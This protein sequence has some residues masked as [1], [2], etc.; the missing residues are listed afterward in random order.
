MVL[1]GRA[2][3]ELLQCAQIGVHVDQLDRTVKFE[4]VGAV[5]PDVSPCAEVA[6]GG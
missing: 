5:G 1:A 2:I 3:F 6:F 4:L